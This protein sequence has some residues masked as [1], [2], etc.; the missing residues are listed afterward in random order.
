[1]DSLNRIQGTMESVFEKFL[2]QKW[3]DA[4]KKAAHEL[5]GWGL[6]VVHHR[7]EEDN[8]ADQEGK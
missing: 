4:L 7:A 5:A 6:G 3:K 1:M 2:E 8:A